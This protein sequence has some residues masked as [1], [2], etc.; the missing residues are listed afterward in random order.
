MLW[1]KTWRKEIKSMWIRSTKA[2]NTHPHRFYLCTPYFKPKH[3]CA[4]KP[5]VLISWTLEIDYSRA[6]ELRVLALTK[7]HV[8]SG[9]EIVFIPFRMTHAQTKCPCADKNVRIFRH[10]TIKHR[11]TEQLPLSIMS[12]LVESCGFL[13][14]L[15]VAGKF[16]GVYY[17]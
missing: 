10:I 2:F 6:P 8:G 4:V 12:G 1:L 13:V 16:A 3:A 9:N 15:A 14:F 5:E 7:R 17:L 11:A